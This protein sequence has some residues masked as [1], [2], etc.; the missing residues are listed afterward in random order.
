MSPRLCRPARAPAASGG[1][2]TPACSAGSMKSTTRRRGGRQGRAGLVGSPG[3]DGSCT[4]ACRA[5]PA[6][7]A[8]ASPAP[9]PAPQP[10]PNPVPPSS[11]AVRDLQPPVRRAVSRPAAAAAPAPA[12]RAAAGAPLRAGSPWCQAAAAAAA[13][14]ASRLLLPCQLPRQRPLPCHPACLPAPAQTDMNDNRIVLLAD[15]ETG[16]IVARMVVPP[17]GELTE[18][19]RQSM[20]RWQRLAAA[21]AEAEEE[22]AEERPCGPGVSL[23]I[24]VLLL[25]FMLGTLSWIVAEE[26][27]RL[28]SRAGEDQ[29]AVGCGL[30]A[31]ALA[32]CQAHSPPPSRA[33]PCPCRRRRGG[34]GRGHVAR[35]LCAAGGLAGPAHAGQQRARAR[36]APRRAA[37]AAHR[38]LGGGGAAAA[39]PAA[40]SPARGRACSSRPPC[41]S[42]P[43]PPLYLA[44]HFV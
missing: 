30:L 29:G 26:G 25:L 15:P 4:T 20:E 37:A 33:R 38:G 11:P 19:G 7:P 13:A 32:A 36:A 17:G 35:A 31:C 3:G 5:P 39:A 18:A 6:T 42:R 43:V 9:R 14:G 28:C 34:G 23:A 22:A 27:A 24:I 40:L 12:R 16:Q 44:L 2:T 21:A 8:C 10:A 1:R 41:S